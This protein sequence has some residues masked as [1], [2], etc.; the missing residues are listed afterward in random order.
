[1]LID[2]QRTSVRLLW[3]GRFTWPAGREIEPSWHRWVVDHNLWMVFQGTGRMW[4]RDRVAPL[5]RGTC[6]WLRPG[7]EFKVRQDPDNPLGMYSVHFHLINPDGVPL[8]TDMPLPPERLA[9]VDVEFGLAIMGRIA[10]AV[11]LFTYPTAEDL[12]IAQQLL[13]AWLMELDARNTPAS[14]TKSPRPKLR[15]AKLLEL[16]QRIDNDPANVPSIDELAREHGCTPSH[17]CRAFKAVANASP[18]E[19]IILRRLRRACQLLVG[20]DLSIAEIAQQ[21]GYRDVYFFSRQFKKFLHQTPTAYRASGT[22]V[23]PLL[24]RLARSNPVGR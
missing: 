20:S 22:G 15:H 11:Q 1:M 4:M 18:Q 17:F 7:W 9:N 24:A 19:F 10:S 14:R 6:L 16:A 8:P 21:A 13:T 5:Q 3:G 23:D 2:W 12:Q